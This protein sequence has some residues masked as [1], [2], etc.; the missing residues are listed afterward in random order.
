[1]LHSRRIFTDDLIANLAIFTDDVKVEAGEYDGVI[2]VQRI[3][4][5]GWI[6]RVLPRAET[7]QEFIYV[8]HSG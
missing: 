2:P 6:F 7:V 5:A 4:V 8:V 1:M 3:L